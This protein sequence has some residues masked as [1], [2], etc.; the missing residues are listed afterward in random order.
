MANE[1]LRL[2][3]D[4]IA[5]VINDDFSG[6]L[7]DRTRSVDWPVSPCCFQENGPITQV[8]IWN[9]NERCYM[10]RYPSFFRARRLDDGRLEVSVLDMLGDVRGK[11]VCAIELE[12]EWITM[13]IEHID[14]SLPSLV[15]PPHIESE[16]ILLPNNIGQWRRGPVAASP[17]ASSEYYMPA[18]GW[19]MRWFGGLRGDNGWMIIA[20]DGYADAGVYICQLAASLGWQTTLGKWNRRSLR[21][22]FSGN[23]YVGLARRFRAYAQEHGI[24]RS[25][26]E[27][28]EERPV[29]GNL[30]GG[31][32]ISFFQGYTAHSLNS[33]LG[34]VSP[35]EE[36]IREDGKV[37]VIMS[38][39]DVATIIDEAKQA[40]MRKGYF[41]VRGWLKGGYDEMH[42]DVW[43][44][45]PALGSIDAFKRVTTQDDPFVTILHDN[46]EDMYPRAPSFPKY[47]MRTPDG[48]PKPGGTW[49]GGRCYMVNSEKSMEYVRRNW[50]HLQTL[51]LRGA[52]TDTV[53]GAHL[54]E[55]YSPEHPLTRAQDLEA[56][57]RIGRFYTQKGMMLGVEYGVDYCVPEVDLIETRY[58]VT[59]GK[60]PPLWLLVYHDAVVTLRYHTGT[61]DYQ[62]ASDMEDVLWGCAKLWPA[63]DLAWWR[64][65]KD[66]FKASLHIDEWHAR[67]ALDDLVNHRYLDSEG[68]VEQTEFSSG[69]SVI[70]N[71]GSEAF[72]SG[73]TTVQP[74]GYA[75]ID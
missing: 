1:L 34:M 28:I 18:N 60:T 21:I 10:D 7:S 69:V 43:P 52:F 61:D 41:N 74:G 39:N 29:V 54:Q 6:I 46:Y 56:K 17:H 59:P 12:N 37:K 36:Q 3:N 58:S 67:V 32:C 33:Y 53:G 26:R 70:G 71:F 27:K 20:E 65:Q 19:N 72:T 4:R 25:L 35:T 13:A 62:P 66:A 64:K 9:R 38:H 5:V 42:P 44:P 63:G 23:G 45:E 2:S 31:R 49:H 11:L 75:I 57:L 73:K 48:R 15:F 51:N 8:A 47:V 68:M 55:D 40:G 14:E 22:G 50:E 24:Y 16:S 30:I